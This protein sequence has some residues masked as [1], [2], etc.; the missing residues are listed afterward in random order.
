MAVQ[1]RLTKVNVP[2]TVYQEGFEPP[3]YEYQ[4]YPKSIYHL[5]LGEK[6]VRSKSEEEDHIK[7]GWSETLLRDDALL[8]D[9]EHM[10]Q[11]NLAQNAQAKR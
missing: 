10:K 6:V 8:R 9:S 2:I 5:D 7:Q 4:E 3:E 11:V 1:K